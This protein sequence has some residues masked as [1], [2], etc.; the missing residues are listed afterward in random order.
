MEQ[1]EQQPIDTAESLIYE[2]QKLL[3]E[4]IIDKNYD[5]EKFITFCTSQKPNGDDLSTWTLDELGNIIKSFQEDS[6]QQQQQHTSLPQT[7]VAVTDNTNNNTSEP[8]SL[9]NEPQQPNIIDCRKLETTI[10]TDKPLT[11]VID[12][13]QKKTSLASN[14]IIYDVTTTTTTSP[15]TFKVQR[16]YNDFYW[17]SKTLTKLYPF[18][19]MPPL[20]EKKF[21]NNRFDMDFILHRMKLLETFINGV[22]SNDTFKSTEAFYAFATITNREQFKQKMNELSS[23]QPSSYIEET[24][25]LDGKIRLSQSE[26]DEQY[27]KK[28]TD[29]F[30]MHRSLLNDLHMQLNNVYTSMSTVI[31]SLTAV[32]KTFDTLKL[33]NAEL[34]HKQHI[35][36]SYEELSCF[37]ENWK[38]ILYKQNEL[39]KTHVNEFY[40]YVALEVETFETMLK[41]REDI[42]NKY[43]VES[44]RTEN[45]KHKVFHTRDIAKFEIDKEDG[46]IDTLRITRDKEYAMKYLCY[47][48]MMN[49]NMIYKQYG[50]ANYVG[51]EEIEKMV[52]KNVDRIIDNLKAFENKFYQTLNDG[53]TMWT[54][55]ETFV[56]SC[57]A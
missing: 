24:K 30:T 25:T 53:I 12:N 49:V 2:K 3:Q 40:R 41:K 10:F 56:Q 19:R 48:D 1:P 36:K 46:T 34:I 33:V 20:P 5:H 18:H 7:V 13:P 35:S 38:N 23:F 16:R 9:T 39:I 47:K 54:N 26:E 21:T 32:N 6:K 29:Y 57:D 42:K 28:F 8:P 15:S 44:T 27:F 14:Y 37:M 55:M 4:E 50:Y 43:N 51:K 52:C 17:L 31:E 45:K 22:S 11:I